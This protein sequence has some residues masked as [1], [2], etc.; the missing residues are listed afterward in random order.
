MS[1]VDLGEDVET[2]YARLVDDLDVSLDAETKNE[3]ALLN[4]ALEPTDPDDL[5]R[6]SLHLFF[7][8]MVETGKL[9]FHLRRKYDCTYDEYLTGMTYES[10]TG[11]VQYPQRDDERR[12]QF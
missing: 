6:R 3:L 4:A 10:M 9:D 7:Q 1:L 11:N 12:Y 5:I 2:E 8:Q